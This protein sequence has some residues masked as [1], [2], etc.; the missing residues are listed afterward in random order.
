MKKGIIQD[1]DVLLY[2]DG[3]QLGRKSLFMNRFPFEVCC[4]NEHV[5]RL[6]SNDEIS[7]FYLY[8]WLDQPIMT[9]EII[10]LNS[11][12]AQPGINQT[13]VKS[14]PILVPDSDTMTKFEDIISPMMNQIFDNALEINKL[15]Q[16]RDTLL[17]KLMSGEIDVSE[18]NCD[19]D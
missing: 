18:V 10:N 8:L 1:Q 13:D 16:L 2:K 4:I 6:Q 5:F 17:P 9:N 14:L 11:N 7:Q 12:S 15:S 19:L 3:A